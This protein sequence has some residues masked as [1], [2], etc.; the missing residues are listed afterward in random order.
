MPENANEQALASLDDLD[1]LIVRLIDDGRTRHR[2][3][4]LAGVDVGTVREI[5]RELCERYDCRMDALP[6]ATGYRSGSPNG[7]L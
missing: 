1:A 7:T 3:A 2:I 6:V 5:V 4:E